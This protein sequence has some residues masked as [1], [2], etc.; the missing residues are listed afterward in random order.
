MGET[1]NRSYSDNRSHSAK[2]VPDQ[3]HA[4]QQTSSTDTKHSYHNDDKSVT[5]EGTAAH[6]N[7]K[8]HEETESGGARMM[9]WN[10][11]SL[12]DKI[13]MQGTC[14]F[15]GAFD[16]ACLC[17]TF[18]FP[19]FDF[20]VKFADFI[21]V[22]WPAER[23]SSLG[24]PSGGL[25]VL[26]RKTLAPFVK[27]IKTNISHI[28][29]LK[30]SKELLK[31]TKD[32]LYVCTYIHPTNSVFYSNKEYEN[33]LDMLEHFISDELAKEEDIDILVSGDLNARIG[34]WCYAQDQS[35]NG[36]D[37]NEVTYDR[38]SK[39]TGNNANGKKLIEICNSLNLT[40]LNG[41]TERN[42][43]NNFTFLSKRGNSVIDYFLGTPDL[44]PRIT[45]FQ[46]INRLESQHLPIMTSLKVEN[47]NKET[48][49]KEVDIKKI[50]WNAT[51]EAECKNILSK[52]ESKKLLEAAEKEL[53]ENN[54][55]SSVNLFTK[56][57]QSVSKPLEYIMK[58][59]GKKLDRKPWYDKECQKKKKETLTQL[60]K[61]GKINNI[62]QPRRYLKEKTKFL[63]ERMAYQKL[64]KEKR[65]KYN[66]E[67]K[68][69][70][71]KDSKD[72]KTFWAT[73]RKLNSRKAKLPNIPIL[74]WFQYYNQLL[75]PPE[76]VTKNEGKEDTLLETKVEEL[77]K[78][79]TTEETNK[80]LDKLKSNKSPG[81]DEIITEVLKSSKGNIMPYLKHLFNKIFELGIFPLQWGLATIIP[82][83]KK[84][85][86]ELCGNYRGI[87]LLSVTSKVFSSIINTRLYNWA[88]TNQK[89]NE[90]Q[91][92]F[93]KNYSTIDHIFT[94][95][96]MASNC[97]YGKKRSK[98]YA[99]FIDFQKAFDTVHRD[100]LWEILQKIGVSTKMITTLKAMYTAIKAVVKHGY[101]KSPEIN[102]T[103]GVRQGCL[104]SPL[105]FSLLV[106]EIAYQVAGGGR[107]GYQM[108]PGAQEIFALLFADDIVLLSLTPI[109]LQTQINN[110]KKAAE[111]IGLIVNLQK[112]KILVYRK[113]GFLGKQEKWF[114]GS[115]QIEVVNSYKYLGYTMTTKISLEIPLAEYAGKAKNK[116][117]TIFKTLYKLGK[118]EPEIFFKLFDVQVKPMVLY[119]AELWGMAKEESLNTIEKVHSFA[120]KKLLGVTPRTPSTM[121]QSELNRHPIIIDAKIR[122]VKYWAKIIQLSENRLPR[123]A[124]ERELKE[125]NKVDNWAFKIKEMLM[126]NGYGYVWENGGTFFMKSFLK[127]LKQRL[128]DQF[129]Q[130]AHSKIQERDRFDMYRTIKF[131]HNREH[132]ATTIE[133]TKFRKAFARLR[134][135][136]IDIRY[137]ERFLRPLSSR[138]CTLCLPQ[139]IDNEFH[140]LLECP[141]FTELRHKYLLRCWITKN[142]LTVI[143]LIANESV[144]V[145]RCCS[146][147]TY[148]ALKY[149]TQLQ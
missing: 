93:R 130:D 10:L 145:T 114:F 126:T 65:K 73:I 90:E 22:H 131:D 64:V 108:V 100:K 62:R 74:T 128:V 12:F 104:L 87:S 28:I 143:D 115:E 110:L 31:S 35:G 102:C 94:L 91:A 45:N 129:W 122:A 86:K 34:D 20:S 84:G 13:K 58:V 39:D 75:N 85:D 83:Y 55:E 135:G 136:I 32:L 42:F 121:V 120:C 63:Q 103:Q 24:R 66:Q 17:E 97:L 88:E 21:A 69:K 26:F 1:E 72:S 77:D 16:F 9:A 105:L 117:I 68:E 125:T 78:E 38:S 138:Y 5:T 147:Y 14:E 43:D 54:V 98:L 27:I 56:L 3:N 11:D 95:H 113:G 15:I 99:A 107:A 119:A 124:Y 37:E 133:I 19:D 137:N 71:I 8:Q 48:E 61:L 89:I 106:A 51:K 44:L 23:F 47:K 6:N 80:A 92:G 134:M 111:T 29:C 52:E 112:S 18:T 123:Q 79:I 41:L 96:C 76:I 70:L 7:T 59:G 33:T 46:I 149:K 40:P 81:E 2:T 30:I 67:A 50:K 146:M 142:N 36:L 101:E 139:K 116:I 148:H 132:Y 127:S 4:P 57:I 109:G 144:F 118:V 141:R 49:Q 140:F 53:E 60:H 25:V 82:I